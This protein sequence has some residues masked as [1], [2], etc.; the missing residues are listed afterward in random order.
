MVGLAGCAVAAAPVSKRPTT[1]QI[2]TKIFMSS[3]P[4][5][6]PPHDPVKGLKVLGLE[7]IGGQKDAVKVT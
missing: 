1:A 6:H 4:L 2:V 5:L 7:I 3:S